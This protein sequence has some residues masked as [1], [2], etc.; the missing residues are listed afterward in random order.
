MSKRPYPFRDGM[1][2]A[3][4]L[5]VWHSDHERAEIAVLSREDMAQVREFFDRGDDPWM[6]DVHP[7]PK[8]VLPR[9]AGLLPEGRLDLE[10]EYCIE[11][12]QALPGGELWFPEPGE[13]PPGHVPP[14]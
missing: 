14:P 10:L 3:W 13:L 5:V 11:A 12:R 2:V 8:A 4:D 1:N 6:Y 9:V 7:V